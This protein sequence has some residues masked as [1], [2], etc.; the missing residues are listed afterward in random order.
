ME[1]AAD[2]SCVSTAAR[3]LR[4]SYQTECAERRGGGGE[5]DTHG[6]P[7][8][9][10]KNQRISHM[11]YASCGAATGPRPF[12]SYRSHRRA[13]AAARARARARARPLLSFSSL[14]PPYRRAVLRSAGA[15]SLRTGG[16][17]GGGRNRS[18]ACCGTLGPW[19]G[20]GGSRAA[21]ERG[22][23]ASANLGG[24]GRG[25]CDTGELQVGPAEEADLP[26]PHGRHAGPG[27]TCGTSSCFW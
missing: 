6:I 24:R 15:Q 20:G 9:S 19:A 22:R 18:A 10:F 13:H 4:F 16:N 2:G 26:H 3:R 21:V 1:I 5:A 27:E 14:M 11:T 12:H 8:T 25:A 17:R 7:Q 23:V